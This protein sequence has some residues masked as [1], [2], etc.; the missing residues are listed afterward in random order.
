MTWK[1]TDA[2]VQQ[3]FKA[4][5]PQLDINRVDSVIA[6]GGFLGSCYDAL[7]LLLPRY[8]DTSTASGVCSV[9][10]KQKYNIY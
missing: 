7:L 1:Q 2:A 10:N 6:G 8:V 9:F 3:N 4:A 5:R